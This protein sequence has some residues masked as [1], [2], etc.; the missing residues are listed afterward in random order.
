PS[1]NRCPNCSG[2][3]EATVQRKYLVTRLVRCGSCKLLFRTPTDPP[4]FTD[5]FY[6][7]NYSRGFTT[8]YPAPEAL[9]RLV[10][11]S[12]V[13]SEKDIAGRIQVF[14]ALGIQPGARV[15]DFGASWGYGTW[16]LRRAE[17]ETVGYEI[18]RPRAR[19]AREALKVPVVDAWS[20]V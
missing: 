17:F 7:E 14:N 5:S 20:D 10:E 15:L 2:R 11:T 12:F 16:Q 3:G 8:D 18:G 4:K 9:A 19:Y 1:R 13:G 6:Q